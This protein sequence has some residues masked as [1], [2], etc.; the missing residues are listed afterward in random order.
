MAAIT[1]PMKR[2]MCVGNVN[3]CPPVVRTFPVSANVPTVGGVPGDVCGIK[4]GLLEVCDYNDTAW[5]TAANQ[6]IILDTN[7]T[8]GFVG[9]ASTTLQVAEGAWLA[10][11][12]MAN[13]TASQ[14]TLAPVAVFGAGNIFEAN[15]TDFVD[16]DTAPAA[17]ALVATD[18]LKHYW[19][20]A[21]DASVAITITKRD[22]TTYTQTTPNGIWCLTTT[23][24]GGSTANAFR[25]IKTNYGSATGDVENNA[26][27]TGDKNVR[28][29]FVFAAPGFGIMGY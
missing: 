27:V 20:A 15:L 6:D 1:V 25:V 13:I 29:Q 23:N 22:G 3:N 10:G 19:L 5:L 18:L 8:G 9:I 24:T 26:G 11:I 14:T 16:G 17:R 21:V 2:I 7:L 28:V 4:S 12:A